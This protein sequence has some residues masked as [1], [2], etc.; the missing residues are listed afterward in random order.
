METRF[1]FLA[2]SLPG[3][4]PRNA[5]SAPALEVVAEPFPRVRARPLRGH[6]ADVRQLC[7]AMLAG[8]PAQLFP[9]VTSLCCSKGLP[10]SSSL[11]RAAGQVVCFCVVGRILCRNARVSV[12]CPFRFKERR[13]ASFIFSALAPLALLFLCRKIPAYRWPREPFASGASLT[14]A[15]PTLCACAFAVS[16]SVETSC[17][18]VAGLRGSMISPRASRVPAH[19]CLFLPHLS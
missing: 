10:S 18:F 7:A 9:Q 11:G 12:R 8:V 17:S 15:F 3:L 6:Y 2:R 4:L 1:C 5:C 13:P 19:C 14:D 16:C